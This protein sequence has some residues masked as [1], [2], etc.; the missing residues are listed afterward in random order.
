[1]TVY[2][3]SSGA[4]WARSAAAIRRI[5]CLVARRFRPLLAH[6]EHQFRAVRS[7][8]VD[9]DAFIELGGLPVRRSA[10]LALLMV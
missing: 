6:I 4:R 7:I 9:D 3:R 1:M 5:T 8:G 10:N 2:W